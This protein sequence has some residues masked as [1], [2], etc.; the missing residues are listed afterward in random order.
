MDDASITTE[1]IVDSTSVVVE[2][3]FWDSDSASKRS[4][5]VK[6]FLH[7]FFSLDSAEF[8]DIVDWVLIRNETRLV[9]V[10]VSALNDRSAVISVVVAS[11]VIDRAGLISEFVL[12]AVREG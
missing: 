4:V 3:I 10:T 11:S 9:W 6:M 5:L 1:I 8:I 2:K 7:G 12:R